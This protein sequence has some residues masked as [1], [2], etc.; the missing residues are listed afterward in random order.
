MK[1]IEQYLLER[2]PSLWNTKIV[3]LLGIAFCAHL[4]FFLFVFFIHR[5]EAKQK[6]KQVRTEGNAQ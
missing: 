4:F 6:E 3:W 5:K 2:Y 1:K